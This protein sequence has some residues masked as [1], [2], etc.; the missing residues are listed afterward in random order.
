MTNEEISG[1][2][3]IA[4]EK[5]LLWNTENETTFVASVIDE[6]VE[7]KTIVKLN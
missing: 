5:N 3:S 4:N 2:S 6:F 7:K 1:W